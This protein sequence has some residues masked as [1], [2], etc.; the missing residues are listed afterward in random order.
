MKFTV[1][2]EQLDRQ[3]QNI[4]RVITVR[5][6]LPILSNLL[7]ETDKDILRISG[8]DLELAMTSYLPAKISQEG[9]FTVP[10]KVFQ[11]FVHQVPDSQIEFTLEAFDLICKSQK[12]EGRIAGI[13]A[14]E[15]PVLPKVE[16]SKK[17]KLP[18]K[19]F[20]EAMKQVVIACAADQTRPVLNGIF[21]Q[22][23]EDQAIFAAT[24]SF[25][26]V[27][28]KIPIIPVQEDLTIL[29]PARTIQE[30]IRVSGAMPQVEDFVIEISEN[31]A[32]F[33]I[34]NLE[35][36][37]RLINGVFPKYQ[38][39][40]PTKFVAEADLTNPEFIGALRLSSVFSTTGVSNVMLE[41][42]EDGSLTIMSHGS[43]RGSLKNKI[44]AI[45]GEGF[46]PIRVA[47][48]S[49]FLLDACN[50]V[51]SDQL[52]IRFSGPTTPLVLTSEDPNLLQLVMPIRID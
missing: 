24:D 4:S 28:K 11:E 41:V 23:I 50:A 44:Y 9:T 20:V 35:I 31:Q 38:N 32:L 45:F 8:T 48:N 51:G 42:A 26:L 16:A 33:R 6:S 49:K 14:E 1:S 21:A 22:F 25:R 36:Y 7:L 5:Q 15:Y 52:K 17:I 18:L 19:S 13:D 12:V 40:I 47:F 46:T 39:I 37:S 2:K 10:A 30:V 3:L 27:E 29:I 43:Q 34:D